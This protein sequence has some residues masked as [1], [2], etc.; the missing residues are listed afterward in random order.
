MVLSAD[1]LGWAPHYVVKQFAGR[2]DALTHDS[3][4]KDWDRDEHSACCTLL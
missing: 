2:S 4:Q 1:S 3:R